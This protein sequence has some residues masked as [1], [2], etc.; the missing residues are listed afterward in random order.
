[1]V[2]FISFRREEVELKAQLAQKEAGMFSDVDAQT[3]A[4]REKVRTYHDA[5]ILSILNFFNF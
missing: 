2:W 4:L 1:M 5:A 3:I